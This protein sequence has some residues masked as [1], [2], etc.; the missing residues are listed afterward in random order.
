[1]DKN[2]VFPEKLFVSGTDTGIGKTVISTMLMSVL[3]ASYWKPVQ[4][5]L[6]EET[7]TEFVRRISKADNSRIISERYRLETPMSPHAAADI[8]RVEIDLADFALPEYQSRHLIVEGA[9]GLWVPL[10]W[11]HSM[12]DLIQ[13]LDIPVLLVARSE[14]GTLNHTLLSLEALEKRGIEVFGVILNGPH[15][16]SNYETIKHFGKVAVWEVEP[17]EKLRKKALEK[18]F[19]K[20]INNI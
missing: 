9:G 18:A 15:H 5:G 4:S 2:I 19:L 10:N 16:S 6:D 13:Q 12:L 17:V 7:D 8:D 3:D 14:L 20:M 11:K 1:M